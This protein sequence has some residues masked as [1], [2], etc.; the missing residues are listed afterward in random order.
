MK[1]YLLGPTP[2]TW[3]IREIKKR[4]AFYSQELELGWQTGERN[5]RVKAWIEATENK[6][7]VIKQK[8]S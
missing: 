3:E 7:C 2:G 6:P 4:W 1:Y 8:K 5:K